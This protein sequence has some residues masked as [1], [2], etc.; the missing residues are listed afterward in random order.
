VLARHG[1]DVPDRRSAGGLP[2]CVGPAEYRAA[3]VLNVDAEVRLVPGAKCDVIAPM[4][5]DAADASLRAGECDRSV[6]LLQP[7]HA[8]CPTMNTRTCE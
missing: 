3:P 5:K 7:L 6:L 8:A 1:I 4:K 2:V